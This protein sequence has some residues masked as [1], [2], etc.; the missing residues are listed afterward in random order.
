MAHWQRRVVASEALRIIFAQ[1]SS[2][3]DSGE[4]QF[5]NDME[6]D[7]AT[8]E[9][10]EAEAAIYNE[11]SDGEFAEDHQSSSSSDDSSSDAIV[12]DQDGEQHLQMYTSASGIDWHST[13][14]PVRTL[15]RNIV[16]FREGATVNPT[17]E[18]QLFF[19]FINECMLS[20][21]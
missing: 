19:L 10:A 11:N 4:E 13:I 9:A 2:D 5:E 16:N 3:S 18:V 6:V 12:E 15:S 20:Y 7:A 21:A 14:P 17:T 8:A 1:D